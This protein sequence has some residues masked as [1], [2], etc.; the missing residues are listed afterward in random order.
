MLHHFI[1]IFGRFFESFGLLFLKL[2][3]WRLVWLCIL[4]LSRMGF[5]VDIVVDNKNAEA[6]PQLTQTDKG[7]VQINIVTPENGLSYNRF[8][9]YNIDAK[10][11]VINNSRLGN[12]AKDL[13]FI[14]ANKNLKTEAAKTILFEVTGTSRSELTGMGSIIGE[15]A[16]FILVNPN[17][18]ICNG[19]SFINA[20][21]VELRTDKLH[22]IANGQVNWRQDLNSDI[23]IGKSGATLRDGALVLSSGKVKV[24][25]RV[26]AKELLRAEAHFA[27]VAGARNESEKYAIDISTVALISAGK[28]YLVATGEDAGIK[29]S[30][31][32]M[33]VNEDVSIEAK[34]PVDIAE[35]SYSAKNLNVRTM[36]FSIDA[37]LEIDGNFKFVGRNFK[38]RNAFKVGNIKLNLS[39]DFIN[40][41]NGDIAAKGWW[42][43]SSKGFTNY[44]KIGVGEA[45]RVKAD[46]FLSDNGGNINAG[47]IEIKLVEKMQDGNSL[48]QG[49]GSI[50]ESREGGIKLIA[51]K[52]GMYFGYKKELTGDGD[53]KDG[54]KFIGS[55]LLS[56]GGPIRIQSGG[57]VGFEGTQI[58][59][60]TVVEAKDGVKENNLIGSY[61]NGVDNVKKAEDKIRTVMKPELRTRVV[62][63]KID[64]VR[65]VMKTETYTVKESIEKP[66]NA[67]IDG[68]SKSCRPRIEWKDVVHTRQVPV[69]EHYMQDSTIEEKY[70]EMVPHQEKYTDEITTQVP[71]FQQVTLM[72]NF[73]GNK[74]IFANKGDLIFG[75]TVLDKYEVMQDYDKTDH[76]KFVSSSGSIAVHGYREEL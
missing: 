68:C 10:G 35:G 40:E 41:V 24:E 57:G 64:A 5:A 70:T 15:Q 66:R 45:F 11:V 60:D 16:D 53:S 55:Q 76:L 69:Q 12:N 58:V 7:T 75:E 71:H 52:G 2:F 59:G 50:L 9:Q 38:N 22:S 67:G 72:T 17:G 48:N 14:D 54:F 19:C 29:I 33:L 13:G 63:N 49:P 28:V 36:D 44:H 21:D 1:L 56:H 32:K 37:P 26:S 6:V 18:I 20:R 39:G 30:V 23:Y 27:K 43:S 47:P 31:P 65:T 74:Q 62:P 51:L 73:A 34:G 25:G 4:F 42:L 46:F 3:D 61:K 8:E